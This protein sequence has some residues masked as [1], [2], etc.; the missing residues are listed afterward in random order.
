MSGRGKNPGPWYGELPKRLRFERGARARLPDL[1]GMQS[2]RP[3]R[4]G[5]LYRLTIPV[6]HYEPRRVEILFAPQRPRVPQVQVDGPN[7]PH[8]FDDGALCM[9]DPSDPAERRWIFDDG[10]VALNGHVAVQL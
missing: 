6:E 8:R 7:S 1:T 5:W 3:G 2:R 4:R 9:W 10:L